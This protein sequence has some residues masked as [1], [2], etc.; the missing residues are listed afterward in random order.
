MSEKFFKGL[1]ERA[2][3]RLGG[4][5]KY[6]AQGFV[7]TQMYEGAVIGID[8]AIGALKEMVVAGPIENVRELVAYYNHAACTLDFSDEPVTVLVLRSGGNNGSHADRD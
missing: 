4:P 6:K 3:T 8:A 7:A 1:R 2:E 5:A